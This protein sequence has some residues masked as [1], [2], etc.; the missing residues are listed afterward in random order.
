MGLGTCMEV[1]FV[2][3]VI[4]ETSEVRSRPCVDFNVEF[5]GEILVED[6]LFK[7]DRFLNKR[8]FHYKFKLIDFG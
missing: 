4:V 3:E 5:Y 6:F 1:V 8:D 2:V 7:F